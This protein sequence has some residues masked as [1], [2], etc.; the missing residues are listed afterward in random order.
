MSVIVNKIGIFAG[1]DLS[2]AMLLKK[3]SEKVIN[4]GWSITVFY[5]PNLQ[6]I[7]KAHS[8][9]G[10]FYLYERMILPDVHHVLDQ[11]PI[12]ENASCF[13]PNGL[14]KKYGFGVEEINDI[15][16]PEF[17]KRLDTENFNGA[18]SLRCLQKFSTQ[19]IQ[20]FSKDEGKFLWNLHSGALPECRGYMPLF[21]TML[22]GQRKATLTLHEIDKEID[23]GDIVGSTTLDIDRSLLEMTCSS[24]DCASSLILDALEKQVHGRVKPIQ[25]KLG[26][27]NRYFS[28]LPTEVEKFEK[29][30]LE[31]FPSNATE[32]IARAYAGKEENLFKALQRKLEMRATAFDANVHSIKPSHSFFS[33]V[34]CNP[35]L[36]NRAATRASETSLLNPPSIN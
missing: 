34:G 29:L 20:R 5:T 35:L 30:G 11:Y 26:S 6:S 24:V 21:R 31:L 19:F 4:K 22:N 27:V 13:S 23:T 16:S 14:S 33:P 25:Q 3:F 15:N 2:T 36:E 1:S 7:K 32:M 9:L 8:R 28:P 17:L 18:L 10:K 12:V